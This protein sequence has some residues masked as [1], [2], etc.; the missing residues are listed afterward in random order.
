[1]NEQFLDLSKVDFWLACVVAVLVLV[2]CVN[3]VF[4]KWSWTCLNMGFVALLL[5][6]QALAL[7]GAILVVHLLLRAIHETRFRGIF[8]VLAGLCLLGSLYTPK[9]A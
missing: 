3:P 2:P 4:R 8:S 6:W 9:T 7:F 5:G 1:M